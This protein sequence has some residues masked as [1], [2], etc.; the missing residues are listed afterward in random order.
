MWPNPQETADMVTFTEEIV[1]GNFIFCA[2]WAV[3]NDS[4]NGHHLNKYK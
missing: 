2:V 1:N 4:Y 3:L